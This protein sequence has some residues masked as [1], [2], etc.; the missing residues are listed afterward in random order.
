MRRFSS[1]YGILGCSLHFV[2]L[3]TSG[4]TGISD[5]TKMYRTVS[6]YVAG[7]LLCAVSAL[8]DCV[9]QTDTIIA[10]Q[11]Q[12]RL[13][14]RLRLQRVTLLCQ[15]PGSRLGKS[16]RVGTPDLSQRLSSKSM[17][18]SETPILCHIITTHLYSRIYAIRPR[19][20]VA[21]SRH[22]DGFRVPLSSAPFCIRLVIR[23]F[24]KTAEDR[25]SAD[26]AISPPCGHPPWPHRESEPLSHEFRA[27]FPG[28][29][30]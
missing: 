20:G 8:E 4:F 15:A 28:E 23:C 3:P 19:T 22:F 5:L 6:W 21:D 27:L 2:I 7:L 9:W 11:T 30:A 24:S 13:C 12:R 10:G 26:T 14:C 18:I 29:S 16:R 17:A 1:K 25:S